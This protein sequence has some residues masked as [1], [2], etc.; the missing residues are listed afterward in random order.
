[1]WEPVDPKACTGFDVRTFFGFCTLFMG[2]YDVR[3]PINMPEMVLMSEGILAFWFFTAKS[4]PDGGKVRLEA[5][6][7]FCVC[8]YIFD[9]TTS[10]WPRTC[11]V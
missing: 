1:M 4:G 3:L 7:D 9:A 5:C 6:V 11:R 2:R 8:V 10:W